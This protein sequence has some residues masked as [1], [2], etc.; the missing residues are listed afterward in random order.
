LLAGGVAGRHR[1][2]AMPS[3]DAARQQETP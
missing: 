2:V 3:R 1:D